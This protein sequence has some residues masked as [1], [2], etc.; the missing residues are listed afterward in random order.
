M[1]LEKIKKILKSKKGIVASGVIVGTIVIGIIGGV[2]VNGASK[3]NDIAE[4]NKPVINNKKEDNKK[5]KDEQIQYR[6]PF[7]G[8]AGARGFYKSDCFFSC[9][10]KCCKTFAS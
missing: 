2:L 3:S 1:N 7:G 8:G 5:D 6:L 9:T 4:N 10:I